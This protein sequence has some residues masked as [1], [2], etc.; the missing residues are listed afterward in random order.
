MAI[1]A[2][3]AGLSGLAQLGGG[4]Y[5]ALNQPTMEN[6]NPYTDQQMQGLQTAYEQAMAQ[7]QSQLNQANSANNDVRS[8]E[9]GAGGV[10]AQIGALDQPGAN[11]WYD[12][13]LGNIPG[14]QEIASNLADSATENLGRS[15]QEQTQFNTQEAT[16]QVQDQFAGSRGGAGQAALGAAVGGQM[17]NAQT[18]LSGQRANIESGTF[19]QLAGQGQGLAAQGQQNEFNN[20]LQALMSQLQGF[21][22]QGG[23]AS[24]RAGQA[25]QAAGQSANIASSAQGQRSQMAD[26]IFFQDPGQNPFAPL[27]SGLQ[28]GADVFNNISDYA[29]L[30]KPKVSSAPTYSTRTPGTNFFNMSNP[31]QYQFPYSGNT[32][33][34][35]FGPRL[36][37]FPVNYPFG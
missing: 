23:L 5:G 9:R 19:N 3:L 11:D 33:Y 21:S 28:G 32:P 31:G 14:Y 6:I 4:I 24:G 34:A 29:K 7:Y 22:T 35:Q 8:A 20:A 26:P 27:A 25:T 16:R 18:Q 10:N 36:N 2:I 12:Q 13:F 37:N 15:I 17:A 1:G 30:S